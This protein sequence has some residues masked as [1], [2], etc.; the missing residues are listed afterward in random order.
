MRISQQDDGVTLSIANHGEV[1]PP[2]LRE[3]VFEPYYRIPGSK[4]NGTGLGLAIVKEIADQHGATVA[5]A[6]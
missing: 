5:L 3:R 2:Q 4:S 6:P 1:I